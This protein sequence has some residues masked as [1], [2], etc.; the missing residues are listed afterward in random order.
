MQKK[1]I[2]SCVALKTEKKKDLHHEFGCL[3][4]AN[5]QVPAGY[6]SS[7]QFEQIDNDNSLLLELRELAVTC[8]DMDKSETSSGT[9]IEP[10]IRR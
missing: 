8:A 10:W 1:K 6:A 2:I 3:M 4:N 9:S 7:L 5:F